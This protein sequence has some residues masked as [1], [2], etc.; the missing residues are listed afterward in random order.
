MDSSIDG[1]IYNKNDS[2]GD[3]GNVSIA[4]NNNSACLPTTAT[5]ASLTTMPPPQPP[6]PTSNN[7]GSTNNGLMMNV[8]TNPMI[9]EHFQ[10]TFLNA[11]ALANRI[12]AVMPECEGVDEDV[13]TLISNVSEIFSFLSRSIET[14]EKITK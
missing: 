2:G 11:Q 1:V 5:S 3:G 14:S 9:P 6:V 12:F 7:D 10:P 8:L 13:L 4:N